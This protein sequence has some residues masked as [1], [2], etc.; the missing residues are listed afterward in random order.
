[1]FYCPNCNNSFDISKSASG[2]HGG[3]YADTSA[4]TESA[5][6]SIKDLSSQEQEGGDLTSLI[7]NIMNNKSLTVE[8]IGNL[9]MKKITESSEYKT[10][11]SKQKEKVYNTVSDLTPDLE[12]KV[13][14]KTDTDSTNL[15]FFVCT[16]CGFSKKI[17]ERT[18]I[19]SRI[20]NE[21]SKNYTTNEYKGMIY[22]DIL[23]RTRKYICPNELC[24][25]HKDPTKKEAIFQRRNNSYK[26][27]YVCAVCKTVF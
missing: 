14:K 2:T 16:N 6:Q 17:D 10:L 12:K 20:S 4:E 21:V 5:E 26:L 13:N 7:N 27:V 22:S 19:F 23:P 8:Q 3:A 18:K 9:S 1:M 25:T 11:S 24:E 15:A